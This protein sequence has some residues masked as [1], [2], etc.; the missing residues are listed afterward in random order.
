MKTPSLLALSAALL[1]LAA[2]AQP[3][4]WQQPHAKVL[5]KGDLEWAPEPLVFE[6]GTDVRYIDFEGGD[7]AHDGRTTPTA[8]KHHPLDPAAGGQAKQG[9]AADTFVF[10]RGVAYRG[11]L[12]GKL[13]GTPQRPVRLTVDPAWGTGEAEI[14]GSERITTWR[15]GAD[16]ATMP[17]A[18]KVWVAELD[19]APRSVWTVAPD[20][21]ITRVALARTPNWTITDPEDVM[22]EWYEWEQPQ[23]WTDK[24]KTKVGNTAMHLGIDRKHL[25]GKAEDY[26]GGLVWSEW[27]I[28]MGTPFASRVESFDATQKGIGFQG[29]WY[30]DSGKIITGNR[31]FLE[32]KPNFLDAPGEFW[33]DKR[34]E[35]GRLH[36][37]LPG[38]ADPNAVRVE[39]ARHMTL[40]DFGEL[41]HVRISGLSFRFS[42]VFWDLTARQFVHRDVQPAAIRLLGA[43]EDVRISHCRFAHVAKAIRLKA[44]ADTDVLDGVVLS[45]NDVRFTDHGAIELEGSGRW[46]KKDP[47]FAFVGDVKVLRNRLFEIGHRPFRS[48]SAHAMHIGFP[49]TL[50]VAGNVL[51]RTYGAGIFVFMGKGS[52]ATSDAPLARGLIHH[53]KVVQPLLAANDWGGIETWQGGPVYVFNNISGNPGGYWNW[54]ANKPGNARLGFA[55]YLD[56]G[57]KNYHFNNI[58]WGANNDLGSKYCNRTAFY[59][60]VPT[61]LNAFFNNTAYRFA[62]GSSWS[63]VGGRQLY[64]GNVWCDLSRAVFSHG[65]QKEDEKAVYDHYQLESIAYSR[66]IFDNTPATFGLLEGAG[67]GE[68]DLAGFRKAAETHRLLASDV[69]VVATSPTLADPAH[70]D[71]RPAANSP[72]LGQGVRVF[73]PWSLSRTVGEWQFRR[74]NADPTVV[75]DEHWYMSPSVVNREEYRNLPRHD[76]RGATLTAASY[77]DGPLE[78]WTAG[79]LRF[80][81]SPTQGTV[82]TLPPPATQDA[83]AAKP[84]GDTAT[85]QPADW[86]EVTT[87]A[88]FVAGQEAA[89]DVRLKDV[90]A[91]QKVLVHLH[92]L[93]AQGW[94]GF[95]TLARST[96]DV[97]GAGPYRFTLKPEAKDGLDAFSLLVA[98]S[99]TGQWGDNTRNA[100]VRVPSGKPAAPLPSR[101]PGPHD[102]EDGNFLVETVFRADAG[103]RGGALVSCLGDRG[104]ELGLDGAGALA[105]RVKADTESRVTTPASVAD[106]RWHHVIAECDRA[107]DELR[108]HLD[109][110]LVATQAAPLRGSA[111]HT[112]DLRVGQGADPATA[113]AG[114]LEFLRI[115]LGTLA[116][117]KTT[118]EE[119]YAWQFDGPFLRDFAGRKPTGRRAAGALEP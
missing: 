55:Y 116:D 22:S 1:A 34:G 92:W 14:L 19:F 71:F 105:F 70:G 113:F 15:Q 51:E 6:K 54:A 119:L 33:F 8:W 79:A 36:L 110:K 99:P 37:R 117:S 74:N 50:E 9:A 104:Y 98:L 108:L 2:S 48:D 102:T 56:G 69:G 101:L 83:L 38:D 68:T 61:V 35:G 63:P 93:K 103:H 12:R 97:N 114:S 10:K 78:D 53:N 64:L 95:N 76:L 25:T 100:T 107:K 30:G 57:F 45:D 41:R 59:H 84:A 66:N 112:G 40:M 44:E 115:A 21:V 49:A 43:G 5:P 58:A 65:K 118:I 86:L 26:V 4:S 91:G 73:V 28:V 77:G 23:W 88:A 96:P 81:P 39:A 27:G 111:R 52:E 47:P 16:P 106:A 72:A 31:Y 11:V 85:H 20:G 29:F 89:V 90:P 82:L 75:L 18:A 60:A 42:N 3:Y 109:G 62:E 46:G 67:T 80:A 87:P 94:G 17:D 24:N 32:D 7:D 13:V